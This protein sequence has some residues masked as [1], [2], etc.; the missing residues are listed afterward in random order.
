[1]VTGGGR[2]RPGV[3][4]PPGTSLEIETGRRLRLSSE[5]SESPESS[6]K[7]SPGTPESEI[8][9]VVFDMDGV[10]YHLDRERRLDILADLT[11]REPSEID[12]LTYGSAFESAAESGAYPD[13]SDYLAEFNRR[14]DADLTRRQ[15]IDIRRTVMTPMSEV[16]HL[17]E[18]LAQTRTVALLTNNVSLVQEALDDIAPKVIRIFGENAHT[19][20]RF[21]A[22][23]PEPEIF[24]RLL[25]HHGTEPSAT[26]FIDDNPAAVAG[27][28]RVGINGI[29]F[30]TPA[31]LSE[32]LRALGVEVRK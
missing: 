14:L 15:W 27:A 7:S 26:V 10:L 11:G 2:W 13:G 3:R 21:G 17:A 1:M 16:L 29:H 4:R 23:K 20:S 28:R 6:A 12:A 30:T 32:A 25:S 5:S 31:A 19:S 8:E 22:R 24:E 9:L 18:Q